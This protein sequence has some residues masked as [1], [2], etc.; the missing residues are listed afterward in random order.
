MLSGSTVNARRLGSAPERRL[1]SDVH[2]Y[3]EHFLLMRMELTQV[4][5]NVIAELSREGFAK[6]FQELREFLPPDRLVRRFEEFIAWHVEGKL[7]ADE[8]DV[9]EAIHWIASGYRDASK[10]SA[11][12]GDSD[13]WKNV[14]Q[15]LEILLRRFDEGPFNLRLK[16]GLGREVEFDW[17]EANGSRE[18]EYEKRCRRLAAEA[19]A[20]PALL[21]EEAWA[22]MKDP[23]SYQTHIFVLA[24]GRLDTHHLFLGQFQ[25]NVGSGFGDHVFGLYLATLK[26]HS[27]EFVDARLSELAAK[28]GFPVTA[29]LSALKF[30]GA[31]VGNRA[32]LQKLIGD[33]TVEPIAVAN[34]FSTGDWL[35]QLPPVEVQRILEFIATGPAG[36]P[37]RMLRVLS[38]YLRAGRVLPIE[39][40]PIAERT[41]RDLDSFENHSNW[42][43][44]RVAIEL[45][46]RD[47]DRAFQLFKSQILVLAQAD[48]LTAFGKW[49]PFGSHGSCEFWTFLC[50]NFPE[51]VFRELLGLKVELSKV[52][53]FYLGFDLE[54]VR[55]VLLRIAT[56]NHDAAIFFAESISGAS[57]GFFPVAYALMDAFLTSQPLR[58]ALANATLYQTG[59]GANL[60]N[61]E[62]AFAGIETEITKGA[63]PAHHLSWL[64]ALKSEIQK[65]KTD[66]SRSREGE[67][68]GWN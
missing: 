22:I 6:A 16:I 3:L 10:Q 53:G 30:V 51:R 23:E 52:E 60:D 38:I 59:D 26:E 56:E 4:N 29:L 15:R 12:E 58:L 18:Y 9:H 20:N 8:R 41:L 13:K 24:L 17:E 32:R 54:K 50:A 61:Y 5:D 62:Q 49:N 64:N 39:L 68:L 31:T 47:L 57:K 28:P 1:W 45:A 65:R 42:A 67:Y 25:S 37:N 7:T 11:H 48:S 44:S 55:E 27:A 14:L 46:R 40:A 66:R 35:D 19:V 63:P 33:K 21:S 2:D 43:S 34:M 36:W